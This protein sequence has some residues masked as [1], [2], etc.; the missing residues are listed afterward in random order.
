MESLTLYDDKELFEL[1]SQ[2][3]KSALTRL[4]KKYSP[5]LL[6]FAFGLTKSDAV[7]DEILQEVFM[8]IW[9]NREKLANVNE[10]QTYIFRTAATVSY[11]FLKQLLVENKVI[12]VVRNEFY[13]DER[14]VP[15]TMQLYNLAADIQDA[16]GHLGPDQKKVYKLNREQGMKISEIAEELSLSPNAVRG[17]LNGAM[18]SIHEHVINKGHNF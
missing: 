7:T 17:L 9:F 6:D 12:S 4:F 3:Q 11:K 2:G 8:R 16:I 13:Y 15:E 10:P 1:I 18:E 5:Q 14:E